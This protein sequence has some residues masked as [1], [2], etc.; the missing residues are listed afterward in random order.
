MKNVGIIGAS[1]YTGGEL[2]RVLVNHPEADLKVAT[3]RENAGVPV[4]RIHPQL[5]K[6]TELE[7]VEP[8]LEKIAQGCQYVFLGLP[9]GAA[10]PVDELVR[11]VVV[12][13]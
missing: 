1:G 12:L 3:S 2:L 11:E 7:F 4:F 13:V 6:L 5:R 8:D 9:H 10:A